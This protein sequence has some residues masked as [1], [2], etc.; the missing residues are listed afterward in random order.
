[1]GK[2]GQPARRSAIRELTL[3]PTA[4][5]PPGLELLDLSRLA[6]R[7]RLNGNDPYASLRPAF[8]QIVTLHAGGRLSVSVD[9]TH[10]E[11][12]GGDWLWIRP[13]QVQRWGRDLP[14][15]DG[16]VIA[17]PPG[18]TGARPAVGPVAETPFAEAVLTPGPRDAEGLRR[19][20]DHLR[21]EYDALAELP[22]EAHVRVLR[23]LVAVLTVRLA[24]AYR[25]EP[26][27][28]VPNEAFRRFHAAV[29]RDFTVTR[30]VEDYAAALGY[31][32]RTLTRAAQAAA[33]MSAKRYI[34]AR[35]VLEAKRE[36]AHGTSSAGAVAARLGFADSSDFTK[37][38]RQR[39]G[40]TPTAFRRTARGT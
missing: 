1:M 16:L 27:R 38:F 28:P 37:F 39:T 26:G 40:T 14:E 34:D 3:R 5:S 24:N 2:N 22:L 32:R 35:V 7:A 11:L 12:T 25:A 19:A 20:L 29:E 17:F 15:A 31:S 21:F 33:G 4:G 6:D 30:R 9:F 36:L 10:H 18:F 13:G 8:H 23:H